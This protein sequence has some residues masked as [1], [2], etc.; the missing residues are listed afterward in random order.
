M[1]HKQLSQ[2]LLKLGY[3]DS[4]G[5]PTSKIF[6]QLK[7]HATNEDMDIIFEEGQCFLQ[8]YNT[9]WD[10]TGHDENKYSYCYPCDSVTVLSSLDKD[11][12]LQTSNRY[13]DSS[14]YGTVKNLSLIHI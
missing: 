10:T 7:Y 1:S 5:N 8:S 6:H 12:N 2:R 4:L 9:F 11:G 3:I 14:Q 13:F